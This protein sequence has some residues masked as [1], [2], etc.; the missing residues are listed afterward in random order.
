MPST[1]YHLL[2]IAAPPAPSRALPSLPGAALAL[3]ALRRHHPRA[4]ALHYWADA[5]ALDQKTGR[6]EL[7][8]DLHFILPSL[9][10]G[11]T[12][13][14]TE[15]EQLQARVEEIVKNSPPTLADTG[16]KISG[17][18]SNILKTIHSNQDKIQDNARDLC[19]SIAHTYIAALLLGM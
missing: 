5:A 16:V 3:A 13:L 1:G 18:M 6:L 15:G 7:A 19:L 17:S 10:P 2:T 4:L 11:V 8:Q 12:Y 9:D 14:A